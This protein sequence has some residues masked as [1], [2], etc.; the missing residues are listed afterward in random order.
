MFF[1]FPWALTALVALPITVVIYLLRNRSKKQVVSALFLWSSPNL[2]ANQGQRIQK[3]QSSWLLFLELIILT[4]LALAAADVHVRWLRQDPPT[5]LILDDSWSMQA[6]KNQAVETIQKWVSQRRI[7]FPVQV[8]RVGKTATRD[9]EPCNYQADLTARLAQWSD[10]KMKAP[11]CDDSTLKETI[12]RF[13]SS[14][15][16][17]HAVVVTDSPRSG[18]AQ[19]GKVTVISVGKS[20]ANLAFTSAVRFPSAVD[21]LDVVIVEIAN[22]SAK[23]QT[24]NCQLQ[25]ESQSP[26]S[27]DSVVIPAGESSEIKASVPVDKTA[28]LEL[29]KDALEIDNRV[30]LPPL[31]RQTVRVRLDVSNPVLAPAVKKA[32]E[33]AQDGQRKVELVSSNEDLLVTDNPTISSARVNQ[34]QFVVP[35]QPLDK[36]DPIIY[37]GPYI[38]NSSNSLM[39][40]TDF[41]GVLWGVEKNDW[42]VEG[43]ESSLLSV[44]DI[45]L[46][47][48]RVTTTGVSVVRL[49]FIPELSSLIQSPNFPIFIYNVLKQSGASIPG[50]RTSSVSAGE[51]FVFHSEQNNSEPLEILSPDNSKTSVPFRLGQ[52][53]FLPY[54]IGV[55]KIASKA[56]TYPASVNAL[57]RNESDLRSLESGEWG[58]QF[59][60]QQK[61]RQFASL[62]VPLLLLALALAVIHQILARRS[63]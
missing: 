18:L 57:N 17:V 61:E 47:V 46:I 19:D 11:E 25:V 13:C 6:S 39:T 56:K 34:L 62:R 2:S 16:P 38:A 59:S 40:G 41:S 21:G 32:V 33:L 7:V 49:R 51:A 58:A 10:S 9:G 29:P 12:E 22:L 43:G 27:L 50:L 44:G 48:Q 3:V 54:E 45:P 14:G 4:L 36:I 52:A 42:R 8:V 30:V 63:S 5:V 20:N 26:R 37:K 55:Y 28:S 53:V 23:N 60:A 24:V 31:P 35:S 1:E 15:K